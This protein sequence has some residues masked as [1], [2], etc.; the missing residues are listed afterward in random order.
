VPI[1]TV[2]L[3]ETLDAFVLSMIESG[4]YENA[5]EVVSGA[6]HA[7]EREEQERLAKVDAPLAYVIGPVTALPG[8]NDM[9]S[10]GQTL[11]ANGWVPMA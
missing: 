6:L 2:N 10:L 4:R 9:Q 7:L 5:G 8:V 11:S 1:L 3:T